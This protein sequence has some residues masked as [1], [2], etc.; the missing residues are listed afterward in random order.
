MP[1]PNALPRVRTVETKTTEEQPITGST[2]LGMPW[3]EFLATAEDDELEITT[4]KIYRVE[5]PG[6]SSGFIEKITGEALRDVDEDWIKARHGGGVYALGVRVKNG[7]SAYERGVRIQGDPKLPST[8]AA[9]TAPASAGNDSQGKLMDLLERTIERLE[10]RTATPTNG[11]AQDASIKLVAEGA[12]QAIKLVTDQIGG[13]PALAED[14]FEKQLRQVMLE[15]LLH[16]PKEQTITEKLAELKMLRD[17]VQ[18]AGGAAGKSLVEQ[19]TE[20]KTAAEALGLTT[21]AAGGGKMGLMELGALAL[22]KGP[23]ILAKM[24]E[25]SADRASVAR[26]QRLRTEAAASVV[27]RGPPPPPA[28]LPTSAMPPAAPPAR[29]P[30]GP[31]PPSGLRMTPLG[32]EPL[33][34]P[35]A[36]A[37][38]APD[39][40]IDTEAPAFVAHVKRRVVELIEEGS[41]GA[42]IV[43]FLYGNKQ[44]AMLEMLQK[45]SPAQITTALAMDPVLGRATR[46]ADWPALLQEAKEYLADMAAAAPPIN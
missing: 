43:D 18:P 41:D 31:A 16:P 21:A 14:G 15:R 33:P 9:T 27:R 4:L 28:A 13:R 2:G 20:L 22:E 10:N 36:P 7:K 44:F 37:E 29:A 11:V 30:A 42:T 35:A 40:A 12:S 45:A 24:Q 19:V 39:A 6:T 17:L 32:D 26:D 5:P 38:A 23:E 1:T 34:A 8:T 3:H 46:H 25:I